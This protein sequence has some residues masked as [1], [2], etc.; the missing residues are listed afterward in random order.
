MKKT[1]SKYKLNWIERNFISSFP[2][3]CVNL[4][5][6]EKEDMNRLFREILN[7]EQEFIT[8]RKSQTH[9]IMCSY[10]YAGYKIY[11]KKGLNKELIKK[12]LTD[13][14]LSFG[15]KFIKWS[16]RIMLRLKLYSRRTIESKSLISTQERYGSSFTINAESNTNQYTLIINKCCFNDF[17]KR[18]NAVELTPIFCEWDKLWS[19]EINR[20]KNCGIIFTRPSTLGIDNKNC[21]FEFNFED[22]H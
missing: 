12:E 16:M 9:Q 11:S 21:R 7:Q 3:R 5:K 2:K 15:G 22:S 6:A 17:F 8:D 13:I 4:N 19:E 18:N 20:N 14:L 1:K 10:I